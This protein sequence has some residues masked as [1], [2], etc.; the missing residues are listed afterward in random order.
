MGDLRFY[1]LMKLYPMLLIPLLLWLYPPRYSGDR[2]VLG[3]VGMYL[4]A[5]LFD[6]SDHLVFDLTSGLV[7][8]HT[9]KHLIAALAVLAVARHLQRRYPI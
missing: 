5:V 3:I 7:S 4:L 8:G 6:R 1:L 9:I 2:T